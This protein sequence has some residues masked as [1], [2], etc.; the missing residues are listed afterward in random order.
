MLMYWGANTF[1]IRLKSLRWRGHLHFNV[2][3]IFVYDNKC[4]TWKIQAYQEDIRLFLAKAYENYGK[5][6]LQV[7]TNF[8]LQRII[9]S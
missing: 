9:N 8:W 5:I 4:V 6:I 3:N 7:S 1:L 2:T